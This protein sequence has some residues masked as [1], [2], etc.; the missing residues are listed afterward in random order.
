MGRGVGFP[1][2]LPSRGVGGKLVPRAP[3]VNAA[4]SLPQSPGGTRGT[5]PSACW[6]PASSSWPPPLAWGFAVSRGLGLWTLLGPVSA[7]GGFPALLAK[8]LYGPGSRCLSPADWQVSQHLQQASRAHEAESSRLSQQVSTKGATLEQTARELEQARRELEQARRELEQ[9]WL[10][11]NSTQEQL[12]L[13][14]AALEGSKEELARVQEEKTEIKEK[15][16]QTENALSTSHPLFPPDC[17]PADWVLYRGKCLF[18]SKE[19]KSWQK[20]K[21][22]C[23]LNSAHLLITKSWDWQTMPVGYMHGRCDRSWNTA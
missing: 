12:R 22:D 16:N 6:G 4:G 13:L 8:G 9:M 2:T 11:E 23:E 17:C 14:E 15:L 10:K 19:K 3:L 20:S 21:E 7:L 18:V 1:G 5:C